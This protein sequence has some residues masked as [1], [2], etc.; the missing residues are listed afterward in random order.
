MT[1]LEIICVM[2]PKKKLLLQILGDRRKIIL[3]RKIS[4]D[5]IAGRFERSTKDGTTHSHRAGCETLVK[6]TNI[7]CLNVF[8]KYSLSW[9]FK[10]L[11]QTLSVFPF[12]HIIIILCT[13]RVYVLYIATLSAASKVYSG[14][15][16]LQ[17][18]FIVK[19]KHLYSSIYYPKWFLIS[20]TFK[21][22]IILYGHIP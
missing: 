22:F 1:C 13:L 3:L 4:Y 6:K 20:S 7:H 14:V 12:I 9:E 15:T 19:W 17:P 18:C 8:R 2:L 21:Q 16:T 11:I 5:I 10:I